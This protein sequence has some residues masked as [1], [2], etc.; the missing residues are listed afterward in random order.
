M[1]IE[2]IANKSIEKVLVFYEKQGTPLGY[3][4]SVR[5]KDG[6]HPERPDVVMM[7]HGEHKA[8]ENFMTFFAEEIA[9]QMYKDWYD[10]AVSKGALQEHGKNMLHIDANQKPLEFPEADIMIYKPI[11][12]F[13]DLQAGSD[14]CIAHEVWHLIEQERG[15]FDDYMLILEGTATYAQN[16]FLGFSAGKPL[17]QCAHFIELR[18]RGA[19]G[20][21][22]NHVANTDN[23]YQSMLDVSVRDQI[24]NDFITQAM[25]FMAAGLTAL[26]QQEPYK[27]KG[28][29]VLLNI[30]AF[31]ALK[32]NLTSEG[33]VNAFR[34]IGS[35]KLA[36]ELEQQDL[37]TM[38]EKYKEDGF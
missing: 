30:P 25:P 1:N 4:P 23:P 29:E 16:R 20:I 10:L 18:Y 28:M 36:N 17:D 33:L 31:A 8:F 12:S 2:D 32:G 26:F 11:T 35:T 13:K 24:Q 6:P 34:S 14:E 22:S 37:S 5:Y 38:I 27:K 15:L 9:P 19:A 3:V 7:V 21:V